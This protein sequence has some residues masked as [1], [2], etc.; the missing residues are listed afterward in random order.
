MEN[1]FFVHALKGMRSKKVA[2]R[3]DEIGWHR[4]TAV[5]IIITKGYAQSC[6]GDA[7]QGGFGNKLSCIGFP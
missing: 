5:S 1:A 4:L 7:R 6:H 2:L 3:L